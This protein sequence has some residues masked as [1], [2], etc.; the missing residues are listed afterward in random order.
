MTYN[1]NYS[2][3]IMQRQASILLE[4]KERLGIDGYIGN[5]DEYADFR[6]NLTKILRE[7]NCI[8]PFYKVSSMW[9]NDGKICRFD[10]QN[11][12]NVYFNI[13]LLDCKYNEI[14]ITS[15]NYRVL[16]KNCYR[17]SEE[18]LSLILDECDKLVSHLKNMIVDA[19]KSPNISDLMETL[20]SYAQKY[21]NKDI[22]RVGIEEG[23]LN[24]ENG[25]IEPYKCLVVRYKDG[26]YHSSIAFSKNKIGKYYATQR[27]T[28][29][30]QSTIDFT[31][32]TLEEQIKKII[33][34]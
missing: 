32:D 6:N 18:V 14:R 17:V 25:D 33:N 15:G 9:F 20:L 23:K 21:I 7:N 8:R 16:P 2:D 24:M 1:N 12:S 27:T 34:F 5:D 31:L 22:Y 29:C 19:N 11:V 26:D 3:E 10:K 28:L 30:G 4:M 13:S